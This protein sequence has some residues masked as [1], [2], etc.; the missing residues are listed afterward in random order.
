[1]ASAIRP[2]G[3]APRPPRS[4]PRPSAAAPSRDPGGGA[5]DR[6]QG[7]QRQLLAVAAPAAQDGPA[8][9]P[10]PLPLSSVLTPRR[11]TPAT[12]HRRR[13]S[14]RRG[15]GS[16][17]GAV[18]P[19]GRPS[20]TA[21]WAAGEVRQEGI[22]QHGSRPEYKVRM[23]IRDAE[24]LPKQPKQLLATQ[25]ALANVLG[26]WYDAGFGRGRWRP[27]QPQRLKKTG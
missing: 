2:P 24:L 7:N 21:T 15:F 11:K 19:G 12:A 4:R 22:W 23:V 26:G 14:S 5:P 8:T 16:N 27:R 20:G 9:N 6:Q 10:Q 25:S 17:S 13:R 18:A 1:M 3:T